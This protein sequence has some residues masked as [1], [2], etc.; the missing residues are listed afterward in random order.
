MNKCRVK[1]N[2]YE[3]IRKREEKEGRMEVERYIIENGEREE[4]RGWK[5]VGRQFREED[6]NC[7]AQLDKE[8]FKKLFHFPSTNSYY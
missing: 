6:G 1:M 4:A 5:N 2:G 7:P 3:K 8:A